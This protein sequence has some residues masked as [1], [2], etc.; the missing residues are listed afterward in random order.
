MSEN[1]VLKQGTDKGY[2][3][4]VRRMKTR[5]YY[6]DFVNHC[7]R[8]FLSTP[9]SLHMD[10]KRK[11]DIDNWLAVQYVW[12][13]LQDESKQVLAQVYSL[14]YRLQEGV[15]MYC[16]KTGADENQIWVLVTKTAAAVAKSRGLV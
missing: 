1:K 7:I 12:N 11:A 9:E 3:Q 2:G 16:E 14:N 5:C 4:K 6:T 13:R 8:F 10:G 15:R